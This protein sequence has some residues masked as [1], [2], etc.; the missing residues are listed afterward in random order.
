[1]KL[2]GTQELT[3][4]LKKAG[5]E[6]DHALRSALY[7]E[8]EQIMTL[9]K[10]EAPVGTD[11]VLR[12]SGFVEHPK[13]VAGILR[14]VLGYGG[15]AASYAVFVHEG[16]GPAVGKPKF[17]P[18]PSALVPWAKKF[19]GAK[20]AGTEQEPGP[21]AWNLARAIGTRGLKPTKYLEKPLKARIR[22]M[23]GRIAKRIR[24]QM[25]G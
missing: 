19:L 1:M 22:G 18:P 16:T 23:A 13:R 17:F 5:D 8:G 15:A 4:A 11:G 3:R 7:I 20:D 25:G 10:Q 24:S 21:A 12:N 6:A 9:S 2:Q 14:V